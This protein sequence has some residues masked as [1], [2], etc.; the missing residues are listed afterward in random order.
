MIAVE[1]AT[2]ETAGRRRGLR[3]RL[4]LDTFALFWGSPL[5]IWQAVFFIAALVF[6]VLMSFWIVENFT[7]V[8]SYT[9]DNWT[10]LLWSGL[11]H[12]VY[13]RTLVYALVA[14]GAPAGLAIWL[15]FVLGQ[16]YILLRHYVKLLF[17]AS[18][19]AYFQSALAH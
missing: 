3:S 16:L 4:R 2:P 17:Y 6:L 13:I 19:T 12:Q 18:Q 1:T 8:R 10:E 5:M 15:A 11:F 7:L 9:V 14:P